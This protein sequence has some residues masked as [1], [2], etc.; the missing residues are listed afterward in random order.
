MGL[1]ERGDLEAEGVVICLLPFKR[2]QIGKGVNIFRYLGKVRERDLAGSRFP[3]ALQ[4]DP[5][6]ARSR[7]EK[8]KH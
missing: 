2:G 3:R 7:R 8:E 4:C 6:S 1:E 5:G